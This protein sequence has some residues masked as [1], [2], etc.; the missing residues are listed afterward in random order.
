MQSKLESVISKNL[1]DDA[2]KYQTSFQ[3]A[4][5]F[6]HLV[7]ENFFHPHF[8]KKMLTDFP[9]P[10]DMDSLRNEFGV[11]SK[12]HSCTAVRSLGDTY[13]ELDDVLASAGFATFMSELTGIDD[14]LYDPEYVGG[15]THNNFEGQG[16]YPHVDFNYHPTTGYHRRLNAIVY[17]NEEWEEEWGGALELHSNAWDG[18]NNEVTTILPKFGTCVLFET[19]EYSWHGFNK[20]SLPAQK[21]DISRKSFAIYMYTKDRP[22]DEIYPKHATIY[23]QKNLESHIVPGHTLSES[24]VSGIK[25]NFRA[26]NRYLQS[27][28]GRETKFISTISTLQ[29]HV[30]RYK[31]NYLAPVSGYAQ[32]RKVTLPPY[33][34]RWVESGIEIQLYAV[35]D[36]QGFEIETRI[37]SDQ[38]KQRINI[39]VGDEA[40]HFEQEKQVEKHTF[41]LGNPVKIGANFSVLVTGSESKSLA[42]LKLGE[43]KRKLSFSLINLLFLAGD[44]R[45]RPLTKLIHRLLNR[46]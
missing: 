32:Q 38:H 17:L 10:P 42:E 1:V 24:D 22:Q 16:M 9:L 33:P 30:E 23:V 40:F 35:Q 11:K 26:R 29:R 21:K 46:Y 43:D 37:P 36:L 4:T 34:D 31:D 45:S 41:R 6:K 12:K 39:I 25:D 20:I 13:V 18:D 3:S 2:A 14:L 27:L 7:I 15:G 5:P 28:Y 19:N 8:A 44:Y